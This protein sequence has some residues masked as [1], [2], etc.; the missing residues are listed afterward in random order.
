MA[1]DICGATCG[2]AAEWLPTLLIAC[3]HVFLEIGLVLLWCPLCPPSPAA[4][5]LHDEAPVFGHLLDRHPS[6]LLQVFHCLLMLASGR[7][8]SSATAGQCLLHCGA[9]GV[10]GGTLG[11]MLHAVEEHAQQVLELSAGAAAE[12]L[13]NGGCPLA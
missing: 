12:A 1:Y 2:L 9:S 3:C 5:H 11:A 10:K 8:L 4:V 7:D 13:P 6:Q